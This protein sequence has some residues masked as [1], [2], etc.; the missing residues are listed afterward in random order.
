MET[1]DPETEPTDAAPTV[2]LYEGPHASVPHRVL[3]SLGAG[4][5]LWGF[6]VFLRWGFG[7]SEHPFAGSSR[8][9]LVGA[10]TSTVMVIAA[11]RSRVAWRVVLDRA[12]R[13]VRVH[14][15]PDV[16]ETFALDALDDV[17]H[18]PAVGGW[19]RD[20][21]ERL[22]LVAKGASPRSFTLPDDAHTPGIVDDIRA[23]RGS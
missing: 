8:M 10:L 18:E 12:D 22:V 6:A 15:D 2:V 20:P 13:A 21:A 11:L 7:G 5:L 14:R 3:V 4:A 9:A 16:V 19:S 23:A 17:R 1:A